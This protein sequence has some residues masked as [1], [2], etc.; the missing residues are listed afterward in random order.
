MLTASGNTPMGE[1]LWWVMQRM[2]VLK[3][4]RKLILILTD[5]QPSSQLNAEAAIKEAGKL[6]FEVYGLGLKCEAI[7]ELLPGRSLVIKRLQELPKALFQ[8][9]GHAMSLDYHGGSYGKT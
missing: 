9:L 2:S 1:A 4:K 8:L 7:K 5:G 6:G 3:E